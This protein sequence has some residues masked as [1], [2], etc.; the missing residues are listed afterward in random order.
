MSTHLRSPLCAIGLHN[1]LIKAK[2]LSCVNL[3]F[4]LNVGT[5]AISIE[6]IIKGS[7]SRTGLGAGAT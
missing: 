4:S 2:T 1:A 7:A 6:N 3:N 5:I